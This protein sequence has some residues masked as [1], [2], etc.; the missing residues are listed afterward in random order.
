[1][2]RD[3]L[4]SQVRWAAARLVT[5]NNFNEDEL[6]ETALRGSV[7]FTVLLVGMK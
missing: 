2:N 7:N 1:M 4:W 5:L 3:A 6:S